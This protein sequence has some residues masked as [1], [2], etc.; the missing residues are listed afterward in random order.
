MKLLPAFKH[1]VTISGGQ[2]NENLHFSERTIAPTSTTQ[3]KIKLVQKFI[4]STSY[5]PLLQTYDN[6]LAL[7]FYLKAKQTAIATRQVEVI[8]NYCW[9]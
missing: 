2:S 6:Y 7:F 1:N 3:L 5:F 9:T 4:Q 8:K